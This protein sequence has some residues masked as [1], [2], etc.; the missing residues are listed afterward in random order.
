MI[1]LTLAL[2]TLVERGGSD[3]HL[4]AGNGP[5]ARIGGH[6]VQLYEGAEPLRSE[7]MSELLL[8]TLPESRMK[9]FENESEL[10]YAYAVPG[11]GRFRVNAFRQRGSVAM[12]MRSLPH[13]I[14][15]FDELGL[16]DAVRE[17]A[18][19]ERGIVL[20]TGTTG[21][22][23][24]TTLAAMVDH[25]NR[26]MQKHIV[27]IEDPIEFLHKDV[28]SSVNQREVGMDTASFKRALHRVLRQDPDVI[29]VG[30]MRDEE[31]VETALSAAE[32]GHLVFSTLHTKDAAETVN[33][34]IEFFEPHAQ[35]QVRAMLASSLA[36]VISQR[37][38]PGADGGRVPIVEVLKTTGRI[39]DMILEPEKTSDIPD[40][41]ADGA[42]YGMQ[43]FDQALFAVV[44]D[45]RVDMKTALSHASRP[46]DFKLLVAG[47]GALGTNMDQVEQVDEAPAPALAVF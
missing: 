10:D 31:T 47:D 11:V 38:V 18:E 22:G 37:L 25:I 9:E 32:T 17:L 28:L 14:P 6:V 8:S 44:K 45:G 19:S 27:T 40:A 41:I 1:D 29:L 13:K 21:S 36:G 34:I 16:P 42:F 43:S 7:E 33:R 46:Q 24:S 26:T 12:V 4:K 35:Q 23:K 3:L 30:E 39:R 15:H 5:L 2:T 20:V